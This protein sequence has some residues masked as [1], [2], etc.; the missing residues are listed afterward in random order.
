MTLGGTANG[1]RRGFRQADRARF[2]LTHKRAHRAN[3]FFD[4]HIRIDAM[5]VVKIDIISAEAF[6]TGVADAARV[7]RR[8]IDAGD[9]LRPDSETKLG[10]DD[11]LAARH[12][13]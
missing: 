3:G 10:R 6:Q 9:P 4:W 8:P 1:L 12:L 2:A 5:L 7:F 13:A 11:N